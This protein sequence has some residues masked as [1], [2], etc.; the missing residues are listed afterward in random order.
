LFVFSFTFHPFFPLYIQQVKEE[1]GEHIVY[2]QDNPFTPDT[3]TSSTQ[4][5]LDARIAP[6]Y[7]FKMVAHIGA[8]F[9]CGYIIYV[10][11]PGSSE[12]PYVLEYSFIL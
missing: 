11:E 1:G 12:Y 8:L 7:L 10:A 4:A 5:K 6:Q 2:L 9:F 3:T